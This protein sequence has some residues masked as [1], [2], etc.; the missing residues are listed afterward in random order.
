M[1]GKLA[2][3]RSRFR[4]L[5]R[6]LLPRTWVLRAELRSTNRLYRSLIA[7][8]KGDEREDLVGKHMVERAL[9]EEELEEIQTRRL[10]H[11][12]WRYYIVAPS[13]PY[14]SDDWD[15]E[16]WGRGWQTGLLYLKPA[17]V[18]SL[19][20][21]IEEAKKRRREVWEAWAKILSGL[22]TGLV[23][24]VSAL[25]SLVLAWGR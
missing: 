24:L 6:A 23:A 1:V 12:A 25:V 14:S 7:Q 10:L 22:I 13:I 3:L 5:S 18:T 15:D 2:T 17:A 19:Q 20:R 21:Q 11:W 9:V 8:A 16:N 4:Q